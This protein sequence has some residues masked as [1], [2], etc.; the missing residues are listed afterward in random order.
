MILID[1][2][3]I[4]NGGGKILL[5]YL[6]D[7]LEKTNLDIFYLLDS[8]IEGEKYFIKDTNK[9]KY[10]KSSLIS[11]YEFYKENCNKFK[12]I[13]I[14]GNIPPP[15]K[16]KPAVYTYFHNSIYLSIPKDFSFI[17]KLKYRLKIGIIKYTS[18]N[19]NYWIVQS[20]TLKDQFIKKFGQ[21]DKINIIPFFSTLEN[22]GVVTKR[23]KKTFLYVSNAQANK[24]HIRLINAFCKSYDVIRDGRLIVT[25]NNSFPIIIEKIKKAQEKGYPIE[26]LGF[27]D[28]D[29][30]AKKYLESEYVIFPSI[31]ES[32]G[33][34]LIEGALLGC[35]I[36]AADL[37][38][39]YA[40]CEPS[41]VFNPFDEESI[42]AII[43]KAIKEEIS[44]TT[45]IIQNQ[46]NDLIKLLH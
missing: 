36:L 14:L 4:N 28:R 35:K 18:K 26:N 3:Y 9:C 10:I 33:L 7:Q 38:Y 5:D 34:G 6:I 32:F 17:E 30:L 8:R 20:L 27:V 16:T 1:A 22:K 24:N 40:V 25:V 41:D 45:L 43:Q 12:K 15:I 39:S 11:R 42:Y 21:S 31:S 37:P 29:T 44:G 2:I 46:I 23:F 19:T 13:F